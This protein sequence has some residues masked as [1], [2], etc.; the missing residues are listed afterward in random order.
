M[1]NT[2]DIIKR[3]ELLI[4]NHGI[5]ASV[6]ADKIGVQRSGLSHLLS[7]RNKP[8]LDFIMKVVDAFPE[9]NFNWLLTG[10]EDLREVTTEISKGE[11]A[12]APSPLPSQSQSQPE[13]HVSSIAPDLF[14]VAAEER[15]IDEKAR[16]ENS[17]VP[18]ISDETID[19]IVVFYSDGTFKAYRPK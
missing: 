18:N 7:G 14:S 16:K 8:S 13:I 11:N 3:I 1:V 4:E 9:V 6:F 12:I 19:R 2:D 15:V 10:N 5:S 17:L